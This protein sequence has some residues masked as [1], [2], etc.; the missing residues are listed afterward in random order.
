[1][2][3]VLLGVGGADNLFGQTSTL[4]ESNFASV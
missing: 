4:I 1:M 2:H 3:D